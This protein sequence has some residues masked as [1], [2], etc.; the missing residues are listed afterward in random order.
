MLALPDIHIEDISLLVRL[1]SYKRTS[2]T[3]GHY[4]AMKVVRWHI[5]HR[6]VDEAVH[7]IIK[8]MKKSSQS[9]EIGILEREEYLEARKMLSRCS[10]KDDD[11]NL[12]FLLCLWNEN[13]KLILTT[14]SQVDIL[15]PLYADIVKTVSK[16]MRKLIL[17]KIDSRL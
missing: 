15:S 17:Q 6:N 14:L 2:Q 4:T 1:D 5:Y 7:F 8:E 12:A 13:T 11:L 9:H 3:Y 16:K 10:I